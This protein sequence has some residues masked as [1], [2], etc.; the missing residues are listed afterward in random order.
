M[1]E[2][3]HKCKILIADDDEIFRNF[4]VRVLKKY[5]LFIEYDEA[6]NGEDA[7]KKILKKKYDLIISDI[8]MPKLN[9][10]E[11]AKKTLNID[12]TSKF[13]II[14]GFFNELNDND[15][16][17]LNNSIFISK[18]FKPETLIEAIKKIKPDCISY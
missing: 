12:P 17:L 7:F 15:E 18:P 16:L 9:G 10:I 4:I 5:H 14:S 8:V 3:K 13:I 6:L 1:K 2:K 11:F